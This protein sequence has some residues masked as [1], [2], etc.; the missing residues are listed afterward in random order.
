[1]T[2]AVLFPGQGSQHKGMGRDLFG[3][4]PG[5]V[6]AASNILEYD[7]QE[8]CLEDP[9]QKLIQTQY[10]QPALYVVN[11]L[12]FFDWLESRPANAG[13]EFLAGHSLGEFN[14][15]MAA[16]AFDFETGLRLVRKRGELMGKAARGAMAA[17]VGPDLGELQQFISTTGVGGIE[18]VNFNSP[19]QHVVAGFEEEIVAFANR[20]RNAGIRCVKLNVSAAFH[21][22]HMV[23]AQREFAEFLSGIELGDPK[24]PVISNVHARP[25]QAGQVGDTLALQ[26]ASPVKWVESIRF[27]MGKKVSEYRETRGSILT[28][29]VNE[30]RSKLQPI[31]HNGSDSAT[32][33][34]KENRDNAEIKPHGGDGF[35]ARPE[36]DRQR[37]LAPG[38]SRDSFPCAGA[39]HLGISAE[40]L[41]SAVFRQRYNARL[42]YVSGSMYRGVASPALVV[43]MGQAGLLGF[44]GTGG[45]TA[46]QVEAGIDY[47]QNR[48]PAGAPF[49]VNLLADYNDPD[50]E[51]RLVKLYLEH[52][53]RNVEASAYLRVTLSL[54]LYRV[55]GL[56]R[57]A[58]GRVCC[59][60]RILAKVSRREAA[61]A[62]MEPPPPTLVKKLLTERKITVDQAE[63]A[64]SIPMAHDICVEAD[65]GGHTDGGNPTILLPTIIRVRDDVVARHGYAEPICVGQAGGIGTP[66]AAATAFMMGGD[67]ILTGSIN[68]C[69][70]EAGTS[71]CVK[72]MLQAMNVEDT[73]Y[74]PAG[75][76]FEMGAKVQVLKKG[77]FFPARGNKLYSLYQNYAS[78]A[79]IPEPTRQM[80]EAKILGKSFDDV[81]SSTRAFLLGKG[82]EVEIDRAEADQKYK[83]GLVFRWYF[84][85]S[86]DAALTGDEAE[87]VNFQVQCGPALGAFNHWVR[88][89]PLAEWRNRHVDEIAQQIMQE[90]ASYLSA[91]FA[92]IASQHT[93]RAANSASRANASTPVN[94]R[95]VLDKVH[96]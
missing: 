9:E 30:I 94:G 87:R 4:Y 50:S 80:V 65:S 20:C 17:V 31:L 49:G 93:E 58:D 66:E 24:I 73:D 54:T 59:R 70:V 7:L 8:L 45:L 28:N 27:L 71:D 72:D 74:A 19:S 26:L 55:S 89:T 84:F 40:D 92:R 76:M 67:F 47:I 69:T 62:F 15:L 14:A 52:G 10:T 56:F 46:D 95:A 3:K 96:L 29:L 82:K 60:N 61:A 12:C 44:F 75:D 64:A 33:V 2:T 22:R 21:S 88:N 23:S 90:T 91:A 63:M 34:A 37:N 6:R 5:V 53:I 78:W 85:R 39:S 81:W 42:A 86:T 36:S 11:A 35:K 25:Y 43:R 83:M 51:L 18:I 79:E 1:M 68:Q 13:P 16:G 48:L 57:D 41:G 38:D 77:V 32:C